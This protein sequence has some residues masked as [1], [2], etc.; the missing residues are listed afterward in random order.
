MVA[1]QSLAGSGINSGDLIGTGTISTIAEQATEAGYQQQTGRSGCLQE[2]TNGGKEPIQ[3]PQEAEL[4]WLE[5][6]DKVTLEAWAG[7]DGSRIGF[8]EVS[9]RV[10]PAIKLL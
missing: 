1:Y 2:A 4:I 9:A 8:G 6:G 3:L 7:S 5:D 10:L